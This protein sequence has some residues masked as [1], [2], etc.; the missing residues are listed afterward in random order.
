MKTSGFE[1][2]TKGIE[3]EVVSKETYCSIRIRDGPFCKPTPI[4][5]YL[6]FAVLKFAKQKLQEVYKMDDFLDG[7]AS[8]EETDMPKIGTPKTGTPEYDSF[9]FFGSIRE[10]VE[11]LGEEDG[12]KLLRAVMIYGT[13]GE[14]KTD[15]PM[16]KAILFS[17]IPN[18]DN[19][20]VRHQQNLEW[21][22]KRRREREE[23]E[24]RKS[25]N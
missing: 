16:I 13:E 3:R 23:E 6:C 9:M 18:I 17:I 22:E 15:D 5:K 21:K 2:I 20:H 12:N 4:I 14:V 7:V 1:K 10:S 19:A 24:R 8:N 25:R 11:A